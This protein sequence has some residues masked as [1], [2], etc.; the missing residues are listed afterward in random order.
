MKKVSK[1]IY[2]LAEI[3]EAVERTLGYAGNYCEKH[4]YSPCRAL[5]NGCED[6][7]CG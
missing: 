4:D 1:I 6:D 7:K 5:D 3:G 2:D